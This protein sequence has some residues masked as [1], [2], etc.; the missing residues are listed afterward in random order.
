M[1]FVYAYLIPFFIPLSGKRYLRLEFGPENHKFHKRD[2]ISVNGGVFSW[3]R[4]DTYSEHW[5]EES[6]RQV[7]REARILESRLCLAAGKGR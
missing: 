3:A 1:M 6:K 2:A 4:R 7:E 5:M